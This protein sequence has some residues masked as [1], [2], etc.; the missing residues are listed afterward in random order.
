MANATSEADTRYMEVALGLARRGL[1]TVWPN[2]SVGCVIVREGR[3]VGRGWTQMGGRPHAE[4]EALRCAEA[5]AGG[6]TVFVSLEPCAHQGGTASC[7]DALIS[8]GISRVVVATG[9]PDP[10]VNGRGMARLA[11]AGI[12]VVAEVCQTSADEVNAG[13]LSRT[14]KGRPLVTLKLAATL[15]G[16]IAGGRG[17]WITGQVARDRAHMLRAEHDVVMVGV[18]TVAADDPRLDCRLPGMACRSP[19]VV[20]VDGTL[21]SPAACNVLT[22]PRRSPPWFVTL[23]S[24]DDKRRNEIRGRGA[25]LIDV[26]AGADGRPDLECALQALAGRGITRVLVE[27]GGRL[28]TAMLRRHLVDRLVWFHA[29]KLLGDEGTPAISSLGFDDSEGTPEFRRIAVVEVG[30]DL[31]ETY[32]ALA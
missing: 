11:D 3:V 6:A 23:E 22:G 14:T 32:A 13:Y 9:D 26:P 20:I 7:A 21:R 8:A 5:L 27:G 12:E 2:P 16:R 25:E 4:T 31:M 29:P 1:G 15:D 30:D 24:A 17:R 18:G 28:A 10:R 19:V